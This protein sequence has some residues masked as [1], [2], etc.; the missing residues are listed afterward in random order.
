MTLTFIY[1][2]CALCMGVVEQAADLKMIP[3]SVQSPC[4]KKELA[5]WLLDLLMTVL[6][7]FFQT[8]FYIC[9]YSLYINIGIKVKK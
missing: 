1:K 5:G 4:L 9:F 6:L 2:K 3:S 8:T 7:D